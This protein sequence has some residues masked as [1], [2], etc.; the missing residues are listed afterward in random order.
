LRRDEVLAWF[1]GKEGLV[2][3]HRQEVDRRRLGALMPEDFD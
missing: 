2:I 1:Y 3:S